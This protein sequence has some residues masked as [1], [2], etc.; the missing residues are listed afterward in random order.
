MHPV[1]TYLPINEWE[2]ATANL[3][4]NTFKEIQITQYWI[5]ES[6]KGANPGS[7]FRHMVWGTVWAKFR[8]L[9]ILTEQTVSLEVTPPSQT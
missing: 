7:D 2:E 3:C 6:P 8:P 4:T 5:N 1:H 9:L